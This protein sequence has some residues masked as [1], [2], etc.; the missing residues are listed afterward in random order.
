MKIESLV[1]I[2][3]PV[4]N[5]EE[6]LRACVDSLL[7][8]TYT[9]FELL[10]IDDGS[11][12]SSAELCDESGQQDCRVKVVHK[13]NGGV[14]SARNLG[15]ALAQGEY[16]CFAD[17]D[18][19][20][21][22]NY[23]K[24]LFFSMKDDVDFVMSDFMY[25]CGKDYKYV[26]P[27]S[28]FAT[29][30]VD[31]LFSTY[32]KLQTCFSPYAK[33]FKSQIIKDKEIHYDENV[34]H[35]EDCIFVF[36]YLSNVKKVAF[37]PNV[38]Y[39]YCRRS[40]SLISKIYSFEQEYYAYDTIRKVLDTFIRKKQIDNRKLLRILYTMECDF[41]NRAINAIYHT[42]NLKR[43]TRMMLLKKVDLNMIGKYMH[44]GNLKEQIIKLLFGLHCYYLYDILRCLGIKRT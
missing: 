12:D 20:V 7:A 5:V 27:K 8:Q 18:D 32:G 2:I 38:N 4:Y 44:V 33:L 37:S 10:L 16:M 42:K 1:S 39:C 9:N 41:A 11:T 17:S 34:H 40:N 6:Y 26:P 3:V 14:S 36:Q 29:G 35:G 19:W 43:G 31:I 13:L 28:Y 24:D 21:E 15:I 30:D 25:T 23:V 22:K